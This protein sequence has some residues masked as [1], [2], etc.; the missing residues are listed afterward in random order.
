MQGT[1]EDGATPAFR[2]PNTM[3]IANGMAVQ[4]IIPHGNLLFFSDYLA[5]YSPAAPSGA[6]VIFVFTHDSIGV[7]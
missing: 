6:G 4:R 7:G 5:A 2:R 1:N 3:G